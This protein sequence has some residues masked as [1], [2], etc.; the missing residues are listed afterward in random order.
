MGDGVNKTDFVMFGV[1]EETYKNDRNK[2]AGF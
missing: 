1:L 2:N